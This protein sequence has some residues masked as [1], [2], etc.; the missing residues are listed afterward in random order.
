VDA[1]R[2]NGSDLATDTA[3]AELAAHLTELLR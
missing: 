2:R 3:Y 1:R